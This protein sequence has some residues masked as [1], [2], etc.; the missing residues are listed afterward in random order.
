MVRELQN[1]GFEVVILDNL[2]Y[3]HKEA[4]SDFRLE[5]ID[6]V[7]EKDNLDALFAAE[8]FDGVIHMASFIQMGES[9]KN[10][11]KYYKNN[12]VGFLNLIDSMNDNAVNNIILS[13]SAGVYGNPV[14]VPIV[15]TDIKNPLNPYGETKYQIERILEDYDTAYGIKFTAIRYFNAAGA[16]LDGSIGEAHPEESHLIPNV[17]KSVLNGTEF[18]LFGDNYD[19]PD[20]TCIRDYIHVLDLVETHSVALQKLLSGESSVI[21]NAGIGR[22]YSNREVIA[23]VEQV[24]GQKVNLKILPKR[25]GDAN[26]LYADITK[27]KTELNWAPKYGLKEI[28]ESA[29]LWHKNH[30]KGYSVENG[31][32]MNV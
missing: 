30:P 19:T 32:I 3:G 16:S 11:S 28:V 31:D 20:G 27:I 5:Q 26:A 6:L 2:S 9:Y 14:R 10:P 1:K 21:Y 4:V 15:E 18:N 23:M 13:S 12:V 22:G 25:E 17:I 8:K 24:T 29:Y 7:T